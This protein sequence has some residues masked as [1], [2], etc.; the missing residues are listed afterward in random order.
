MYPGISDPYPLLH[1]TL[2]YS[3]TENADIST[4]TDMIDTAVVSAMADDSISVF[5]P[6]FSAWMSGRFPTGIAV[7][8]HIVIVATGSNLS[9]CII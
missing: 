8:R 5:S 6:V 1:L 7:M 2:H 9:A 4:V 3:I